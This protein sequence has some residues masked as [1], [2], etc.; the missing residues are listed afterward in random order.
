VPPTA[1]AAAPRACPASAPQFIVPAAHANETY[2]NIATDVVFGKGNVN[3]NFT[4]DTTDG[5]D[6]ALR[7]KNYGGATIDGISG[8]YH[9]KSG[10]VPGRSASSPRAIWNYEFSINTLNSGTDLS[11]YQFRLGVDNNPGAGID[12]TFIDPVD[13]GI[14]PGSTSY[15]LQNSENFAFSSTPGG[16]MDIMSGGTYDFV[17]AAYARNTTN[18]ALVNALS[19]V[20]MRAQV[21]EPAPFALIGLGLAGLMLARRRKQ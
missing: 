17:L 20:N 15:V 8:V 2:G 13:F 14:D 3:G 9:T 21:P 1:T 11:G 7:A 16:P 19:S 18:F 10:I 12:Y 4:I 5:L 6:L